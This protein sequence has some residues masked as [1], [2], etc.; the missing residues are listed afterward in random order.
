MI[1]TLVIY[2]DNT[3]TIAKHSHITSIDTCTKSFV[4]NYN[5]CTLKCIRY[6][7]IEPAS[8]KQMYSISSGINS[9]LKSHHST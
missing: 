6:E 5:T 7:I 4:D 3:S 9:T 8:S 1:H 2:N